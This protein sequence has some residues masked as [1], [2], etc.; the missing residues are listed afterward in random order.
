MPIRRIIGPNLALIAILALQGCGE[1]GPFSRGNSEA[2]TQTAAVKEEPKGSS[3]FDLFQETD[4]PN[5]TIAV[6]KYLWNASLE[7]LN[8]LPIQSAD[9]FSGVI[10]TGYGTPPG[11]RTAYRATILIQDPALDA[12]SLN[13]AVMSRRGPVDEATRLA[14]ENSILARAR[15]LRARDLGL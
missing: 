6:N 1:N 4:D 2:N 12:R 7:V 11:G 15:Q 14:V 5:T 3:L 13:V 8:F 10:S 9:P